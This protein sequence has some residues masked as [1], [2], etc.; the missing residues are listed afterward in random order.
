[1]AKAVASEE[2]RHTYETYVERL[3]DTRT[4]PAGVLN[5]LLGNIE[6][7][8]DSTLKFREV[9]FRLQDVIGRHV[10]LELKNGRKDIAGV[11]DLSF[12]ESELSGVKGTRR[13]H[14]VNINRQ[15]IGRG[16]DESLQLHGEGKH[17]IS[18]MFVCG[19]RRELLEP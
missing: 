7:D 9:A 5:I 6:R 15:A 3:S 4:T 8:G 17:K 12:V 19:G 2:A 16:T 13:S 14:C 1:M 11:V 10:F 18:R